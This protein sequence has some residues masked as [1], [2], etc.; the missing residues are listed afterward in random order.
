VVNG[1][2][3]EAVLACLAAVKMASVVAAAYVLNR[4]TVHTWRAAQPPIA[5]VRFETPPGQ[6]V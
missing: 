1:D 3:V 6:Q 4:K 5:T 2:V